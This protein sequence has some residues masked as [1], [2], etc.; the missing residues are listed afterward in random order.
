MPFNPIVATLDFLRFQIFPSFEH[1]IMVVIFLRHLKLMKQ[2]VCVF[3]FSR[4]SFILLLEAQKNVGHLVSV[5]LPKSLREP[6]Y[7]FSMGVPFF[8]LVT[9]KFIPDL[10]YLPGD[11][12]RAKGRSVI[13]YE[14]K[15]SQS[16]S[17]FM[18]TYT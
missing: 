14:G 2:I 6:H 17:G 12:A 16:L 1:K 13:T 8:G 10:V 5:L 18:S 4:L 15:V 9:V 3:G 11:A 7:F